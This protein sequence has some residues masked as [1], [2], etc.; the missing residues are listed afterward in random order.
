MTVA[1]FSGIKPVAVHCLPKLMLCRQSLQAANWPMSDWH[2]PRI[3]TQELHS[4]TK[5]PLQPKYLGNVPIAPIT[6]LQHATDVN[7]QV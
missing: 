1:L 4:R 7:V 6:P 2:F 5:R 3:P